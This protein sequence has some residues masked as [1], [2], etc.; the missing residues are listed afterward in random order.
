VGVEACKVVGI[1]REREAR[2]CSLCQSMKIVERTLNSFSQSNPRAAVRARTSR[3]ASRCSYTS[4]VSF[5]H[6]PAAFY[7]CRPCSDSPALPAANS[8]CLHFD[9]ARTVCTS[10]ASTCDG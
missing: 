8:N 3:C 6:S 9:G 2:L 10:H 1:A 4:L 5:Y 7:V